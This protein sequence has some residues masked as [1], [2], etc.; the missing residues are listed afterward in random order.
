V[1]PGR[2]WLH[3]NRGGDK[4]MWLH[5][6]GRLKPGVRIET[7]APDDAPGASAIVLLIAC[8]NPGN[9][10]LARTTTS[11]REISVR[12]ALGASRG[13]LIRQLFTESMVIASLGGLAG[14]GRRLAPSRRIARPVPEGI[15]VPV[16]PDVRVWAL[17]SG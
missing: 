13:W 16:T 9:L 2:E 7:G 6:F 4:V 11:T 14:P 15:H 12:L 17:R 8:A 3:E 1:L 10:L 5:V